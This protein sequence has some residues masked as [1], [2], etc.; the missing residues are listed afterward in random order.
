M[1]TSSANDTGPSLKGAYKITDHVYDVVV[2]GA[3]GSG[4]QGNGSGARPLI[5]ARPITGRGTCMT[6]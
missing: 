5:F 6:P 1:A 3:G 2:V 4:V